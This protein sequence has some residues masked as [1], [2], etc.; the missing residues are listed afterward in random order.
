MTDVDQAKRAARERVWSLLEEH[1]AAPPD[2]FGRIPSFHGAQ[3]AAERLAEL[4]E[5]K[6]A[7][8]IKA[9]PDTA[10]EPVRARALREGKLVY[11]A[12]PKLAEERPFYLLD[13]ATLAITPEEAA[14]RRVAA[15]V[16]QPVDVDAMRPVDLVVCGSVA[17]DR[18]GARLGKGAGYSDIEVALLL[19]A[20]L[21]GQATTI[22]STVHRLQVVDGELPEGAHDFRV[23]VVV[24]PE[25][26]IRCSEPRRPRGLLWDDLPAEKIEAI[27]VLAARRRAAG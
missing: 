12:V 21:I 27:P 24:T 18:R 1:G 9:V 23:D 25:G 20:G 2:V 7:Q 5:W 16:G 26:V 11:M 15:R 3:K 8:V 13:P 19:E 10:Q 14:N 22:V 4:P 17:V 6:N